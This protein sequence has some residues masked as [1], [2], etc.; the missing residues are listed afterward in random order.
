MH[1]FK[2]VY[3][4]TL[5]E[6][7][8]TVQNLLMNESDISEV[9][10]KTF[11]SS[12]EPVKVIN[13]TVFIKTESELE[14]NYI[15]KKYSKRIMI[16]INVAT[17]KTYNLKFVIPK[18]I[19]NLDNITN[20][21]INDENNYYNNETFS[22]PVIKYPNLNYRYTFDTFVVG[23]N[24]KLAHAASLAVAE[25]PAEVYNPLFIY[26]GVGLGKTHLMH[27]IAQFI[28]NENKK[29]KVLYV[30]SEKFTNELINSI[31]IGR[32]EDF[33]QKYRHIDVLLVDDIQ[34][35]AG[36][37]STQEEFFHTFNTLYEAKK[38]IIISS[39][40]PP[41]A[42][43]TLEERL[44]SRFEWGLIA[45]IQ[46]PDFETRLAILRK[47]SELEDLEIP[48]EVSQYVAN[49]IKSNIR[50]LEGAINKIIAYSKLIQKEITLEL[51]QDA[52]KDLISPKSSPVI[53]I[54][55][56]IDV[57]SSHYNLSKADIISKKRPRE[58]SY[59][60]QI[61]MYLCRSLTEQSLPQIGQKLGKRDHTTIIHGYEKIA[62]EMKT[63]TLLK[64]TID[65][66]TKKI[67]GK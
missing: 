67:T 26:G 1:D 3:E 17:G 20:L 29:A 47:K 13:D 25:S 5:L 40:R 11:L 4:M 58:I 9:T 62:T 64:N 16:A 39:D 48:Y 18:E 12:L 23:N 36:K 56:I 32:N 41:K 44:R 21:E 2:G 59:P 65:T 54:D 38:Q 19:K 42:I 37:E 33:R 10:Y 6:N 14:R 46:A 35:I 61:V 34:F 31:K 8:E 24:N 50:E 55:L 43:E 28:L 57:V 53:T 66:L 7:W 60:R 63:D 22:N 15:E 49:N 52:L 30:S 45:D 51:A 27:S